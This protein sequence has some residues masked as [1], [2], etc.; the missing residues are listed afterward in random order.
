MPPYAPDYNP[1]E[2]VWGEAKS[3]ISNRQRENFEQT[4][5]AF[6]TF[7]GSTEFAYRI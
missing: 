5:I 2:K 4:C 3:A 7:I 6:E 1:I